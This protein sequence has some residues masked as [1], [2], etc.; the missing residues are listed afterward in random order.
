MKKFQFYFALMAMLVIIS[1]NPQ[2][3]PTEGDEDAVR[4]LLTDWVNARNVGEIETMKAMYTEDAVLKVPSSTWIHGRDVMF[5]EFSPIMS[6]GRTMSIDI[7]DVRFLS[8]TIAVVY[9]NALFSGGNI[10]NE[11]SVFYERPFLD[12]QDSAT[13]FF[14]KENGEW[15]MAEIVVT[16]LAINYDEARAGIKK[17]WDGF[18]EGW[19]GGD[20]AATANFITTNY[21]QGN[22]NSEDVIGREGWLNYAESTFSEVSISDFKLNT[23]QLNIYGINAYERGEA[24]Q[25]VTPNDGSEPYIQKFRFSAQWRLGSD[26]VWRYHRFMWHNLPGD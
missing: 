21:I 22:P 19:E 20:A 16:P 3:Q 1:C 15:K 25:K 11:E 17:S 2:G 24:E 5:E 26:G 13:W 6:E 4:A 8:P 23:L 14:K 12:Y 10:N 7:V 9:V 18:L